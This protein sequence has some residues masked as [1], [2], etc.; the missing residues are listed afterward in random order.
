MKNFFLFAV[1]LLAA[2][3]SGSLT[4]MPDWSGEAY[5]PDLSHEMIVL[6]SHLE[7]PYSV[8][9]MTKALSSLYPTKADR[10]VET[11]HLYVRFLPETDAELEQLEG[12]GLELL[13]ELLALEARDAAVQVEHVASEHVR[14]V[15]REQGLL[16]AP[17]NPKNTHWLESVALALNVVTSVPSRRPPIAKSPMSV[18]FL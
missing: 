5:G 16:V 11:T 8:D 6:G 1:M 9:N 4:D 17:G 15:H 14:L 18:F 12:L 2:S 13:D 3:C 7:D 10:V